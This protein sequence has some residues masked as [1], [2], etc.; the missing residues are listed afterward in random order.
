M[1]PWTVRTAARIRHSLHPP[2]PPTQTPGRERRLLPQKRPWPTCFRLCPKTRLQS[3]AGY[4]ETGSVR[5]AKPGRGDNAT[6][7]TRMQYQPQTNDNKIST[8][9]A[10][11]TGK[12]TPTASSAVQWRRK[13][14]GTGSRARTRSSTRAGDV[15]SSYDHAPE[16]CLHVSTL[17]LWAPRRHHA[18]QAIV[19][20]APGRSAV[21]ELGLLAVAGFLHR[22]PPTSPARSD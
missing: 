17:H 21:I 1:A 19:S 10:Q 13:S 9:K 2:A 8:N 7:P 3:D 5:R 4:S 16:D 20:A 11:R 15:H 14:S 22:T 12:R 18:A 6:P